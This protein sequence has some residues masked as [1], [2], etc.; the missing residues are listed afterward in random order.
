MTGK[1]GAAGTPTAGGGALSAPTRAWLEAGRHVTVD[2]HR[3]FVHERGEG[4]TVVFIHGFPTSGHDWKSVIDD[5]AADHRCIA[6]DQLGYGLSDK[7]RRWSYSLFQ[8]AD[9]VE[10][11]L[12]ALGVDA[13]HLVS[14]DVGTS[15]HTELVARL[16][17]GRLGF[18]MRAAT[19]LNGSMIKSM[20]SLTRFQQILE[21]PSRLPEA[22]DLVAG[23]LGGYVASLRR[24]MARR[25]CI[26]DEDET[27]MR[28]VMA[29]Q[30]GHLNIPAVYSYVRERYLH[31]ETW[32][33]ALARTDVPTQLVWGADDPVAVIG[34][35]RAIAERLPLAR[36]TELAGVGHFVPM[37][38]PGAVA[39]AVRS[40]D[41]LVTGG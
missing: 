4:P 9:V 21:T 17:E 37:E 24:V 13:V 19:F 5:L 12:A 7:P 18:G 38:A 20:A 36:F 15:L 33:A 39:A 16:A 25:E 22:R 40:H 41:A 34:M 29:Y 35:G 3:V 23:M 30:D 14:H 31:S 27:V 8:Q 1:A 28:E 6:F 32:L 26:S 11:L 2:G 10:G